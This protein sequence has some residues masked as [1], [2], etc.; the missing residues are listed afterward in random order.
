MTLRDGDLAYPS[1]H[2]PALDS[3][4]ARMW[5]EIRWLQIRWWNLATS[6]GLHGV[7]RGAWRWTSRMALRGIGMQRLS[8]QIRSA[9]WH[10]R[11]DLLVVFAD[12]DG[13]SSIDEV[14]GRPAAA[15]IVRT[16]GRQLRLEL[17]S[18]ALIFRYGGDEYV[19]F[20]STVTVSQLTESLMASRS[21]LLA[22]GGR[23]FTAGIAEVR[24]EDSAYSVVK[25]AELHMFGAKS[26]PGV[27]VSRRAA[28]DPDEGSSP[29]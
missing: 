16:I 23:A 20:L 6:E 28:A 21:K 8:F 22:D 17:G 9:R 19:C 27:T 11:P 12:V 25:R 13:L 24:P 5:R 1:K 15:Q 7:V 14:F 29:G 3:R 10:G 4:L 2:Q 18:E 26:L